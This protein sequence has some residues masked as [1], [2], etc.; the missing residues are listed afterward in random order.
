MEFGQDAAF[1]AGLIKPEFWLT[2]ESSSAVAYQAS[3]YIAVPEVAVGITDAEYAGLNDFG[4]AAL[5]KSL[6]TTD[7]AQVDD[8][9]IGFR[10]T[11]TVSPSAPM[12]SASMWFSILSILRLNSVRR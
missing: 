2:N 12:P 7:F 1:S 3:V 9:L 8:H 10:E 11:M 5:P 4:M 6:T